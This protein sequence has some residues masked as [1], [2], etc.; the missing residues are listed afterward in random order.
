VQLDQCAHYGLPQA[1]A[2]VS[3]IDAV[4]KPPLKAQTATARRAYRL[5]RIAA[6]IRMGWRQIRYAAIATRQHIG[7]GAGWW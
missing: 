5:R 6:Q 7:V 4:R 2:T 1:I 3:L